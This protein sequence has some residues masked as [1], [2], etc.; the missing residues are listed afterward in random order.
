MRCLYRHVWRARATSSARFDFT[1]TI[2]GFVLFLRSLVLAVNYV[3]VC[4]RFLVRAWQVWQVQHGESFVGFPPL[5]NCRPVVPSVVM[6]MF[7]IA[8][9]TGLVPAL[10]VLTSFVTDVTL[11]KRIP[12]CFHFWLNDSCYYGLWKL[13]YNQGE[14]RWREQLGFLNLATD[15]QIFLM[16][17]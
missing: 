16:L 11:F 9:C 4:L 3:W 15:C 5:P 13:P 14:Q 6:S 7:L 2:W 10:T 1:I 8:L 17:F 12:P